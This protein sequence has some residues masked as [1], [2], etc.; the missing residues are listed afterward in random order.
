MRHGEPSAIIS[1]TT[2]YP[3]SISVELALRGGD[4]RPLLIGSALFVLVC[5]LLVDVVLE[6]WL[7]TLF[8]SRH[9]I[10][11]VG[12][13]D[14]A[15][16]P[17]TVK[18]VLYFV[19][20]VLTAAKLT[21]DRGWGR[22]RTRADLALLVL[23]VVL[24]LAGIFGPSEPKLIGEGA[25]RLPPRGARLLRAAGPQPRPG[26]DPPDALA[27]GRPGAASRSWSRWCRW[28][29]GDRRTGRWGG[30][31]C[32]W[33]NISRAQ[34]LLDHPNDL[35]HLTGL[36]LLGLFALFAVREKV[37][38]WWWARGR[39]DALGMAA[40]Q[41][42]ESIVGVLAGLLVIAVLRRAHWRRFALLAVL[43]LLTAA[44]PIVSRRTP[45]RVAAPVR[46]RHRRR[47]DPERQGV[48]RAAGRPRRPATRPTARS[49]CSTTSRARSCW[50]AGRCSATASASSAASWPSRTT[51]TGTRTRAS[52]RSASTSTASR[53]RPS[54]RSGCT[55][56]SRPGC[57][58]WS[59]TWPG[60]GSWPRRWCGQCDRVAG[61][62]RRP[63][64]PAHPALYWAPAAILFVT[65]VASLSASLE[66]PLVPPLLFTIVGIAWV[67][68]ARGDRV[69]PAPGRHAAGRHRATEQ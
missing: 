41:S 54:T 17:K 35:G 49:G 26:P 56:W 23:A 29:S 22:L 33:A 61:S 40:S 7:V 64:H 13:V 68:L 39:G 34:G 62:R 12:V 27:A 67:V 28:W 21:V 1:A 58:G 16:W 32:T 66:D 50:S 30:S 37:G 38:R 55:W 47:A 11:G 42:R 48:R 6:G 18:T 69:A 60:C 36:M 24:L 3:R 44:I 14:V 8:G 57:S 45:G 53:P 20:A 65:L 4:R 9:D 2:L 25:V 63:A 46:R 5:V 43:I 15:T 51:R 31:T 19:L 59:P 52:S 10:N